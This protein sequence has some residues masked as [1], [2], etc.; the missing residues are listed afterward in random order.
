MAAGVDATPFNATLTSA[1]PVLSA[2]ATFENGVALSNAGSLMG[3]NGGVPLP[4]NAY[5]GQTADLALAL[6]IDAGANPAAD[7]HALRDVMLLLEY[8]A[9]F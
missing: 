1:S 3:G 9:T 4:L 8:E 6:E 7:F 2:A 5:A